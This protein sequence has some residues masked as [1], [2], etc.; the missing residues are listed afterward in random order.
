MFMFK[1]KPLII[2]EKFIKEIQIEKD[3]QFKISENHK[4]SFSEYNIVYE[5]TKSNEIFLKKK[6]IFKIKGFT[7]L[8]FIRGGKFYFQDENLNIMY[9]NLLSERP[10]AIQIKE[11][12]FRR[13]SN[14]F[15]DEKKGQI[16]IHF[17]NDQQHIHV[18]NVPTFILEKKV[19]IFTEISFIRFFFVFNEKLHVIDDV[20]NIVITISKEES[21]KS[22]KGNLYK[23]IGYTTMFNGKMYCLDTTHRELFEIDLETGDSYLIHLSPKL[24]LRE[25]KEFV[26]RG[27]DLLLQ[28]KNEDS[29][30]KLFFKRHSYEWKGI[31]KDIKVTFE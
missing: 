17:E 3:D 22:I 25:F 5:M 20:N 31:P 26:V 8:L 1:K 11:E 14:H 13:I 18:Y 28:F 4:T 10:I 19:D 30:M 24:N 16:Y 15:Y 12:P 27:N 6:E 29:Y 2:D 21:A 7:R 23:T 9:F